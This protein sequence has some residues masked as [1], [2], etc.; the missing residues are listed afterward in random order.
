[1]FT[2]A[3]FRA[4]VAQNADGLRDRSYPRE[5][6]PG[7]RRIL[8]L[9]DSVVWCWGVEQAD[10]F[11]ERLEAALP[12]TDVINAGV[13]AYST[14]QEMLF[15][16]RDGRRYRSDLVLLVFVP[17]DVDENAGARGPRFALQDGALVAPT[18]PVPRRKTVLQEWL[19]AHSR[20]F[21]QIDYWAAAI[22]VMWSDREAV[23][24]AKDLVCPCARLGAGPGVPAAAGL[25]AWIPPGRSRRRFSIASCATCALTAH[26]SP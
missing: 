14:A 10:C 7:R 2:G 20:L 24:R 25:S 23:A 18:H 15:Y 12:D 9:G 17:N 6:T 4:H 8:V 3:H 13:P 19:Q 21:A 1:M 22:K 5:R 26:A 11:T 16:E